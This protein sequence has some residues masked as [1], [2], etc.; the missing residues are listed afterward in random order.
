M[1]LV[2]NLDGL[3]RYVAVIFPVFMALASW[4][5]RAVVAVPLV[6]LSL[7]LMGLM[8]SMFAKWYFV[9]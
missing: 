6:T 5:Q 4:R 8:A 7:M 3:T 9:G 1:A 2:V